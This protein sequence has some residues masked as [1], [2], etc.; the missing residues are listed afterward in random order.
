[1]NG[2]VLLPVTFFFPLAIKAALGEWLIKIKL[3]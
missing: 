3:Q 1:M 2:I